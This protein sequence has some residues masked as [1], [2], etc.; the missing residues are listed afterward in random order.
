MKRGEVWWIDFSGSVGGEVR[1][2]RPALTVSNESDNRFLNRIQ[3][4]PLTTN[5]G[6]FYPSE[7]PVTIRGKAHKAMAD[8]IATVSK[9]RIGNRAGRISRVELQG[10]EQALKVQLGLI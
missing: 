3:V 9:R 10:V 6:R 5:I 4:V 2:S 7:A 1:K 8:Q